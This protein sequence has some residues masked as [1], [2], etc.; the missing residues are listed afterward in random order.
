[1]LSRQRCQRWLLVLVGGAVLL[2][3]ACA[4]RS[5]ADFDNRTLEKKP[6]VDTVQPE[7]RRDPFKP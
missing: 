2:L 3:P 4:R 6:V 1:M 7:T 5:D